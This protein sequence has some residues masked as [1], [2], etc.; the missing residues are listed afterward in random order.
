[1]EIR[2]KDPTPILCRAMKSCSAQDRIADY[3]RLGSESSK[4]DI[5]K[6]GKRV[7]FLNCVD[8]RYCGFLF[9]R[10]KSYSMRFR[11]LDPVQTAAKSRFRLNR[12]F[13]FHQL[14]R[15]L[16]HAPKV[17]Y[18]KKLKISLAKAFLRQSQIRICVLLFRNNG[19]SFI[20]FPF[21]Q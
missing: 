13:A 21:Q 1:M 12:P 9:P 7:T 15:N 14:S 6:L 2:K 19:S 20:A 18:L 17:I 11:I 8:S 16:L 4:G 5:S 3:A 10:R